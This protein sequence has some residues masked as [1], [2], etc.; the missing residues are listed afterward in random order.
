MSFA[1]QPRR[2]PSARSALHRASD[3]IAASRPAP[4]AVVAAVGDVERRGRRRSS[5]RPDQR[6]LERR[7]RRAAARAGRRRRRRRRRAPRR[8][9]RRRPAPHEQPRAVAVPVALHREPEP[10]SPPGRTGAASPVMRTW[11]SPCVAAA[12]W[13]IARVAATRPSRSTITESQVRATS[14]S[15][16]DDM[17]TAIPS[18]VES[19]R[20]SVQ[21]LLPPGRVE[22]VRRLVQDHQPRRVDDRLGEV[23]ALLHPHRE[24]ADQARALL[25]EPDL[26]QHLGRAQHRHPPRQ[27]A[28]LAH[29]DDQVARRHAER[30]AVVLG[31]VAE[32]PRGSPTSASRRRSRARGSGPRRP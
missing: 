7:A 11:T 1:F 13:S 25:L 18:S 23:R 24:R 30:Q 10:P 3:Q 15:T 8:A 27:A 22:A 32:Q 12:A 21:H 31:H 20:T 16:C 6:L 26:E 28:Q 4:G 14:S 9:R 2:A 29:M 5:D 19:R 17:T